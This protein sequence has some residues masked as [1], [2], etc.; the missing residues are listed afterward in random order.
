MGRF[1]N[2]F[3]FQGQ[4]SP[5]RLE[6]WSNEHH[7][8]YLLHQ[9]WDRPGNIIIGNRSLDQFRLKQQQGHSTIPMAGRERSYAAIVEDIGKHGNVG[10]S[11]GG[12][13]PKFTATLVRP[14]GKEYAIS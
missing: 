3:L 2:P 1:A 8:H 7:L 6:D 13:Q 14:K 9:G 12:E 4:P 11:A 5:Q 10:S